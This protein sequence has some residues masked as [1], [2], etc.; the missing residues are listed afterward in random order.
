[1]NKIAN[2]PEP[3]YFAV[4]FTSH[5]TDGDNGYEE[6][7]RRMIELAANQPGFLGVESVR[8]GLGITV[9]YWTDMASVKAWKEQAEHKLAQEKGKKRW[10]KEYKIRIT[11]VKR[12]YGFETK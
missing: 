3:P 9:S 12:D 4:I 1:M 6:T 7:V 2:I 8:Q 10:Y 11:R 5:R